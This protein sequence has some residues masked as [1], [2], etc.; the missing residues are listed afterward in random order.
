MA[1]IDTPSISAISPILNNFVSIQI[2]LPAC[3]A[4]IESIYI[5]VPYF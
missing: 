5:Q 1:G 2:P 4:G 3:D